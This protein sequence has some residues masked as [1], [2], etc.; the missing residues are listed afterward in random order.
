VDFT[1]AWR[2]AGSGVRVS[3]RIEMDGDSV[4]VT[5]SVDGDAVDA[6]AF[7]VPMLETDGGP[8]TALEVAGDTVACRARGAA[9]T[10]CCRG[11]AFAWEPG[12]A[13]NRNGVYRVARWE[14]VGCSIACVL[15][16]AAV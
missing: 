4:R 2:L 12:R 13:V 3:E 6:V 15:R 9:F 14:V 5:A 8:P 1:L 7:L 16:L 10:A 11:A